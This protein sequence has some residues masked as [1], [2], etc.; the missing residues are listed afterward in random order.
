MM[1]AYI[2]FFILWFRRFSVILLFGV[3]VRCFWLSC[4]V[5]K[6]IRFILSNCFRSIQL[7]IFVSFM[8]HIQKYVYSNHLNTIIYVDT[9]TLPFYNNIIIDVVSI[10]IIFIFSEIIS[11]QDIFSSSNSLLTRYSCIMQTSL[12]TKLGLWRLV[13]KYLST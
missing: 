1:C 13:S 6:F 3:F 5:I 7:M 2:K 8:L 9:C 4:L 12:P 10:F 11:Y